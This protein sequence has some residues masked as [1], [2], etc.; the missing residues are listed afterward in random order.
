MPEKSMQESFGSYHRTGK[1]ERRVESPPPG[2][3]RAAKHRVRRRPRCLPREPV[4]QR[5]RTRTDMGSAW[6]H[7]YSIIWPAVQHRF[8]FRCFRRGWMLV[9]ILSSCACS[10]VA[11]GDAGWNT[12]TRPT[13]GPGISWPKE[14]KGYSDTYVL[15]LEAWSDGY[16]LRAHGSL[17]VRGDS[18]VGVLSANNSDTEPSR[19]T[20]NSSRNTHGTPFAKVH[21]L[22]SVFVSPANP[23]YPWL[24]T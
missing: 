10:R 11:A 21:R 15:N 13:I 24:G 9:W 8:L 20:R 17:S 16:Y 12:G 19:D 6:V 18:L 3:R 1:N 14:S 7:S 23:G 22:P 5:R 2:W 4:A